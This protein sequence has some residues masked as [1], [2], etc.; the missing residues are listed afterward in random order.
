MDKPLMR[1]FCDVCGDTIERA[2]DGYVVWSSDGTKASGFM[3]IH[4]GK[5]DKDDRPASA[6]LS[7]FLGDRGLAYLLSFLSAGAVQSALGRPPHCEIT[8]FDEFVDFFRRVQAPYYEEA[9]RHFRNSDLLDNL[10]DANEYYPYLPE[11]LRNIPGK[12]GER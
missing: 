12:Y 7:D 5:C 6:A 8:D 2:Q 11:T 3:I 10:H 9:R 4:Q 1:W